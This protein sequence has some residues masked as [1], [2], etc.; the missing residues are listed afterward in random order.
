[1]VRPAQR[2]PLFRPAWRLLT[3]WLALAL[4]QALAAPASA[5]VEGPIYVVEAGDTLSGIARTF[6]VSVESLA[7][8][9]G[10]SDPSTIFP[11]QE[12]VI[13]G[14]PGVSGVLVT[15]QVAYGDTLRS[16]GL[17]QGVSQQTLARLNRVIN[18]DWLHVG[19][20]L[21]VPEQGDAPPAMP[22]SSGLWPEAGQGLLE[23]AARL[24]LNP[25]EL[26]AGNQLGYRL[27]ALPSQ[28]LL[29]PGGGASTQA[30][31]LG[32]D[33][34]TLGPLPVAQ[35][36]TLKLQID[37][38]RTLWVEG[39]LG[40]RELRLVSNGEGALIALQGIHALA[41]PGLDDLVLRLYDVR[42]GPLLDQFSQPLPIRA[43]DYG[44]EA[45]R[46]PPETLDPANTGPE[47]AL[48]D[49]VVEQTRAERL[50]DGPFQYPTTYYEAFPSVFGTR[51]SYN[52]SDYS[53]YHTGLDLYGSTTTQVLAPARG[54]VVLADFLTVRGNVTYIDHGWGVFSGFLHQSQILVRP[55]E[56]VT[57]GQVIGY[58][59]GTGRVTGPHLHWE[60][61]V[62]GVPV[63]PREWVAAE[64]P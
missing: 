59:G 17:R 49:S 33:R 30:L 4:L 8:A 28:K 64:F 34:V 27:W 39:S 20:S 40:D 31:P 13:P 18:P 3:G 22:Q 35:G 9:N 10:I 61:W 52:G 7:A 63:D 21:I 62:G 19:Q 5:Q 44:F 12:L 26:Q 46:V 6:G 51:R 55:G 36:R 43:G 1:V 50:W 24:N 23:L 60:V 41:Q 56:L 15:Q 47:D 2:G 57:P 54:V 53:Y 58:V 48:V 38:S 25:W 11:G 45:L 14:F 29:V 37:L 32:I 42:G 16:A